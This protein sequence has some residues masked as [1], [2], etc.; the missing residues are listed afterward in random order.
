MVI[1]HGHIHDH[2]GHIHDACHY[3]AGERCGDRSVCQRAWVC[4]LVQGERKGGNPGDDDESVKELKFESVKV[5]GE[6]PGE[7]DDRD[8]GGD[9]GEHVKF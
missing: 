7:D 6:H 9:Y 3:V 4:R 8:D 1:H 2:P 5:Q